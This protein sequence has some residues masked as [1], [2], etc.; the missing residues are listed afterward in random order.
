MMISMISMMMISMMMMK[1]EIMSSR[2]IVEGEATT[3]TTT[4]RPWRK[5]RLSSPREGRRG[6]RGGGATARAG[7]AFLDA[8]K[9]VVS[10]ED[11]SNIID[12]ITGMY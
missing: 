10:R 5:R 11:R 7:D 12:I 6:I 9:L 1:H 8:L 3:T 4:A 2:R